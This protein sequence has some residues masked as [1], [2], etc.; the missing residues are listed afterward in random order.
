MQVKPN[1][2]W[3]VEKTSRP[4]SMSEDRRENGQP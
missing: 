3:G 4:Y 1:K 2:A